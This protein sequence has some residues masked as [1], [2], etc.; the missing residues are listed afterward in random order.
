MEPTPGTRVTEVDELL[1]NAQLRDEIEPFLDE[2][3]S[4]LNIRRLS[5]S[6]END[7]LASML[8]WEKA[9]VLPIAEWFEPPLELPRPETLADH[10]LSE[11][12]TDT[13]QRLADRGVVLEQTEHL[14]DRQLYCVVCRDILPAAEKKLDWAAGSHLAWNCVDSEAD[15]ELWLT[16]YASDEERAEFAE[17]E[18]RPLPERRPLPYP[19]RLPRPR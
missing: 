14:S 6:Q 18:D 13:L 9:P 11:V 4:L 19:R 1:R 17:Q 3:V 2:S 7:F 10:E 5:T 12:L 15:E 16:F 8:A